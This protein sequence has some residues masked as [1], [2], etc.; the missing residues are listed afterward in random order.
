MRYVP[1]HLVDIFEIYDWKCCIHTHRCLRINNKKQA[2]N[3]ASQAMDKARKKELNI[4]KSASENTDDP[5]KMQ[6]SRA[7]A[8]LVLRKNLPTA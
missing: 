7:L 5:S 8:M 3:A 4:L 2:I 6:L 1:L